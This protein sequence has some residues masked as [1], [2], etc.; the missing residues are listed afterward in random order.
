MNVPFVSIIIPTYNSER[1]IG[2][3]LRAAIRQQ[4][5]KRKVEVLV[6]DNYSHDAT[7]EIVR[8]F[9][10]P[11]S[12]VAGK[13]SQGCVQRNLGAKKAK[14]EYLLFL[15]HDME[16]SPHLLENFAQKAEEPHRRVDAWYIPEH[17]IGKTSFLSA[18]RTYEK[19]CYNGTVINAARIIK[20][21]RFEQTKGGYDVLLSNGPADW[22]MDMQ[23]RALGCTFGIIDAPVNHHEEHLSFWKY[24]TKK[25]VFVQG[26]E[27]YKKKWLR[28]NSPVYNGVIRKQFGLYYRFLGV[29]IEDK[30]WIRSATH[31]HLYGTVIITKIFFGIF[32]IFKKT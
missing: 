20:K 7:A 23:L 28:E 11:F 13:P 26:I 21:E 27:I 32:Y 9:H 29:F 30:K 10:I 15:D 17:V 19:Y 31:L 1:V 14:G 2:M 16:M 24:V 8:S 12:L 25:K 4:Y 22:D 3:C 18:V 6:V 5:P